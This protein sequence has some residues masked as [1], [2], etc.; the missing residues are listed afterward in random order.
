MNKSVLINNEKNWGEK[1][2]ENRE[3]YLNKLHE[4]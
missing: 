3:C 4:D 1:Q 2:E